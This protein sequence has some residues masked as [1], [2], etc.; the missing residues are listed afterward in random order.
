MSSNNTSCLFLLKTFFFLFHHLIRNNRT[1]PP[2]NNQI[3][4]A[5]MD[6]IQFL[7]SLHFQKFAAGQNKD[8]KINNFNFPNK[9]INFAII[10][11]EREE[12]NG[13]NFFEIQIIKKILEV[14]NGIKIGIS[15]FYLK[16]LA[17]IKEEIKGEVD[18]ALVDQLKVFFNIFN[19]IRSELMFIFT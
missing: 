8:I 1:K 6:D 16:Q 7:S 9:K 18:I 11:C 14:V 3:S 5:I 10:N 12:L 15:S 19:L 17:K 4:A 2:K 13:I